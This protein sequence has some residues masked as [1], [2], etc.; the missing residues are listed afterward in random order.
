LSPLPFK[1]KTFLFAQL[2]TFVAGVAGIPLSADSYTYPLDGVDQW[3]ALT[4]AGSKPAR[5]AT[6][7]LVHEIG[8]DNNIP[9]VLPP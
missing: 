9:Q 7:G 8:G 5:G 3:A 4:T 2:P 1:H 6:A